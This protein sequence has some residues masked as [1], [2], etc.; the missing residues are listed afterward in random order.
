[1]SSTTLAAVLAKLAGLSLPVKAAGVA[2]AIGV[3][4]GVPA[5]AHAVG[6]PH[7]RVAVDE[8]PAPTDSSTAGTS[9]GAQDD[10]QGDATADP[11]AQPT[12]TDAPTSVPS[13]APTHTLP[14]AAAFG[15]RVAADARDGGVDGQQISQEARAKAASA[16]GLAHRHGAQAPGHTATHPAKP[17]P[18]AQPTT[19]PTL[20]AP[21][22]THPGNDD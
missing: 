19:R 6:T 12:A 10:E 3:I 7:V 15:Q 2:V 17:A 5:A 22:E 20:P 14:A 8:T 9:T 13:P 21:A 18:S 16:A 4:G 1:M 11:T